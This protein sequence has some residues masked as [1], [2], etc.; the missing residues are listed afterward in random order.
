MK[1]VNTQRKH[2]EIC[3]AKHQK[4]TLKGESLK[5]DKSLKEEKTKNKQRKDEKK[6]E[7]S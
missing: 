2:V 3:K 6:T 4:K 5:E 7:K 1:S